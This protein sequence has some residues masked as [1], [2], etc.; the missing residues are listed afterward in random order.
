MS[1]QSLNPFDDFPLD[2]NPLAF[3]EHMTRALVWLEPHFDGRD[4]HHQAIHGYCSY[5]LRL[6][7]DPALAPTNEEALE[8]YMQD[9]VTKQQFIVNIFGGVQHTIL[10]KL[11][12]NSVLRHSKSQSAR[13]SKPRKFVDENQVK[14]LAKDYWAIKKDRAVYGAVKA[15]AVRFG[16]TEAAVRLAARRYPPDSIDQ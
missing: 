9:V 5:Y 6:M 10:T 4:I 2:G 12:I 11:A 16:V 13:A 7:S 8:T 1:H 3:A 15:L 14:R